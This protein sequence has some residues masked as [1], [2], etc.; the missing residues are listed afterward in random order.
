[1]KEIDPD[2][3]SLLR[4][5]SDP[6]EESERANRIVARAERQTGQHDVATMVGVHAWFGLLLVFIGLLEI[7]MGSKREAEPNQAEADHVDSKRGT[8]T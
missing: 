1:M 5:D 3:G 7:L 8:R 4:R 2:I 6:A